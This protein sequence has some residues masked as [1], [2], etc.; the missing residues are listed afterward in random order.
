MPHTHG[1][2][3]EKHREQMTDLARFLDEIFNGKNGPKK[4]GFALLVYEFGEQQDGR[5]NY[6][7]NG[8]RDD[9]RT[10]LKELLGRWEKE[11]VQ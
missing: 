6:I 4:V 8:Q 2:I 3:T 11:G 7:G 10:A 5:I 1:P 9:V